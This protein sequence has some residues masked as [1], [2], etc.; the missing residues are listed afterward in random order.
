MTPLLFFCSSV[1]SAQ[2]LLPDTMMSCKIVYFPFFKQKQHSK[3]TITNI[4]CNDCLCYY[5]YLSTFSGTSTAQAVEAVDWVENQQRAILGSLCLPNQ[6]TFQQH[7][8]EGA[9]ASG[10]QNAKKLGKRRISES[11]DE[12]GTCMYTCISFPVLH[13]TECI[14]GKKIPC[15]C[16]VTPVLSHCTFWSQL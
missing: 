11:N 9:S 14:Q 2:H 15:P 12:H 8:E 1:S 4:L 5:Y 10:S 6:K 16:Q 7:M 13:L 3:V